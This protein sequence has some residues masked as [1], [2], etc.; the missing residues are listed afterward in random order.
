MTVLVKALKAALKKRNFSQKELARRMG[1][2]SCNVNRM[3]TG[4][5]SPNLTTFIQIAEALDMKAS[6]LMELGEE[7]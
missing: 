7:E 5:Q 2:D 6:E 4:K 1:W 3:C